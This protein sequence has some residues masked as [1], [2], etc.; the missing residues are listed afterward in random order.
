MRKQI[1]LSMAVASK[2]YKAVLSKCYLVF[3]E[4][5][6]DYTQNIDRDYHHILKVHIEDGNE[7]N[8]RNTFEFFKTTVHYEDPIIKQCKSLQRRE[9]RSYEMNSGN[10]DMDSKE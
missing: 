9:Q 2:L 3:G 5:V 10:A 8:V 7:I 1:G 4:F 6:S